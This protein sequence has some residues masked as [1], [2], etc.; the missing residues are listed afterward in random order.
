MMVAHNG[1]EELMSGRSAF[2]FAGP[3]GEGASNLAIRRK[4]VGDGSSLRHDPGQ[5]HNLCAARRGKLNLF[6]LTG[7]GQDATPR[8]VGIMAP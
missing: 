8:M 1:E 4:T 2:D 7:M 6:E 5:H 3:D